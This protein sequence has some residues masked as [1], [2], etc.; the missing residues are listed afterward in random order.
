MRDEP[1][2]LVRCSS[3]IL[4]SVLRPDQNLVVPVRVEWIMGIALIS[5][6]KCHSSD[7][8]RALL[9]LDDV[10]QVLYFDTQSAVAH[11]E[12][13]SISEWLRHSGLRGHPAGGGAF[14]ERL[15]L[16][17]APAAVMGTSWDIPK[18][19]EIGEHSG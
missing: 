17:Q 10:A 1:G 12:N 19:R 5:C 8:R 14:F 7:V 3:K 6:E 2:H 11:A 18:T 15:V 16:C 9:R 4:D 13:G